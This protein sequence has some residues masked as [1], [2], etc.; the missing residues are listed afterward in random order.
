LGAVPLDGVERHGGTEA[1]H[2]QGRG[3][4]VGR[5]AVLRGGGRRGGLGPRDPTGSGRHGG[6]AARRSGAPARD[7]RRGR[8]RAARLWGPCRP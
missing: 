4:P 6:L 3:W 7:G 2:R 1:H 8:P 5:R